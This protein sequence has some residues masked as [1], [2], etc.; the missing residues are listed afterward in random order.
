[1][2]IERSELGGSDRFVVDNIEVEVDMIN[3]EF[4]NIVD[5]FDEDG[6]SVSLDNET[7]VCME[8]GIE[9]FLRGE[10]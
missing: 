10:Y 6:C 8:L 9:E 7:K 1:M 2:I 3:E 5:A 4:V